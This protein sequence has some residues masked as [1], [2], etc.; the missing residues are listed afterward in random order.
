VYIDNPIPM[1]DPLLKKYSESS[2]EKIEFS[3]M[4][5]ISFSYGNRSSFPPAPE[6]TIMNSVEYTAC[7]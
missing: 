4:K 3:N 6:G 2:K 1:I 7:G 5:K